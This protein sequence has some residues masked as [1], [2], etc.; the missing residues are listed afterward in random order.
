LFSS[1]DMAASEVAARL[2][3]RSSRSVTNTCWTP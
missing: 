1:R 3:S 2:T